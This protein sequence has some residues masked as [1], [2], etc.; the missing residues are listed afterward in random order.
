MLFLASSV[1]QWRY[2]NNTRLL[3]LFITA[4]RRRYTARL[5][6]LLESNFY[7]YPACSFGKLKGDRGEKA[8]WYMYIYIYILTTSALILHPRAFSLEAAALP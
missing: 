4:K 3:S 5:L 2:P 1:V 7:Q 6:S 8:E